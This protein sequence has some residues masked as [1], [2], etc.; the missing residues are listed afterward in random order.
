MT[1]L[2]MDMPYGLLQI[3]TIYARV[4]KAA[5]AG[6]TIHYVTPAAIA[7][8]IAL[9]ALGAKSLCPLEP[10]EIGRMCD[11]V[12]KRIV[13]DVEAHIGRALERR[14]ERVKRFDVAVRLDHHDVGMDVQTDRFDI[15]SAADAH[16]DDALEQPHPDVR[17]R[18]EPVVEQLNQPIGVGCRL[19]IVL[20]RG[21]A[22]E[23]VEREQGIDRRRIEL[24]DVIEGSDRVGGR[25]DDQQTAGPGW[26]ISAAKQ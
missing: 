21:P 12:F 10:L 3:A 15:R 8:D 23:V 22:V 19:E 7:D 9:S 17:V 4:V 25:I 1:H 14:L 18:M 13:E 2:G 20:A 16:V 11:R 5:L 26:P 6:I 24:P